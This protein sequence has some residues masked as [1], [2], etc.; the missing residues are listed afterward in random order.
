[1]NFLNDDFKR[2]T[3]Q[4][5]L[6][7][8]YVT[9]CNRLVNG[10]NELR[11]YFYR[12]LDGENLQQFRVLDAWLCILRDVECSANQDLGFSDGYRRAYEIYVKL[13]EETGKGG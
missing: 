2:L 12:N 7:D 10:I 1:M 11:E 8:D 13:L 5:G 3:L 4:T 9:R 6:R